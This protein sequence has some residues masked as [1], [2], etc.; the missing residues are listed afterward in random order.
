MF[1]FVDVNLP[2]S[3]IRQIIFFLGLAPWL[4]CDFYVSRQLTYYLL[5]VTLVYA[6]C[7]FILLSFVCMLVCLSV[8][9]FVYLCDE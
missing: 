1:C 8:C 3:A 4:V 9:L 6:N 7:L 5:Y 2:H